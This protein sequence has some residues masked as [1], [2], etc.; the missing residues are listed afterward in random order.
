MGKLF[1]RANN[2]VA[3]AVNFLP[4]PAGLSGGQ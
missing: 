4:L 3:Q 1:S 2:L